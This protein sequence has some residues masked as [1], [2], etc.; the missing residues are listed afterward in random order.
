MKRS[1]K[2]ALEFPKVRIMKEEKPTYTFENPNPNWEELG[3]Q[4]IEYALEYWNP[5]EPCDIKVAYI[6][7]SPL[8]IKQA[9]KTGSSIVNDV[10]PTRWNLEKKPDSA[11]FYMYAWIEGG[12]NLFRLNAKFKPQDNLR[13]GSKKN[14]DLSPERDKEAIL[15]LLKVAE[16][17]YAPPRL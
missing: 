17:I 1:N 12:T 15:N 7:H 8:K 3:R 4:W 11:N 10:L 2:K 16:K 6:P 14:V 13:V 9:M 5:R